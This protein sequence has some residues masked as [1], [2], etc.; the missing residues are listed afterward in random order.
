MET[1]GECCASR[2]NVYNLTE[3][4]SPGWL[5]A[6]LPA[7]KGHG[8]RHDGGDD[9]SE[10]GGGHEGSGQDN[11]NITFSRRY[12]D[13]NR[14]TY[15]VISVHLLMFLVFIRAG[16]TTPDA[17]TSPSTRHGDAASPKD[18]KSS[19]KRSIFRSSMA[20]RLT[21]SRLTGMFPLTL[22]D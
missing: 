14:V 6:E 17:E 3:I 7:P 19:P 16:S 5:S 4:V 18:W 22:F 21:T 1:V 2:F 20:W 9:K 8:R 12:L 13:P 10:H 15:E 11:K